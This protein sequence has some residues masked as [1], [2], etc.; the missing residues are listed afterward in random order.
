MKHSILVSVCGLVLVSCAANTAKEAADAYAPI[1]QFCE[2]AV[3]GPEAAILSGKTYLSQVTE[4]NADMLSNPTTPTTEESAA[5]SALDARR[6]Q[7]R[8]QVLAWEEHYTPEEAPILQE[9][10]FKQTSAIG[11]LIQRKATFGDA[12]RRIY[13]AYVEAE[14]R[15]SAERQAEADKRRAAALAVLAA[16]PKVQPFPQPQP[17]IIPTTPNINCTTTYVGNQA[18]TNCH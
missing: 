13:E 4:I 12:N 1:K 14:Q 5:L 8:R 9:Q 2:Q 16:T 18:Y 11:D 10:F 6:F 15:V 17:Y 3:V 7:C